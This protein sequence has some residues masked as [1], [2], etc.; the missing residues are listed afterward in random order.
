MTFRNDDDCIPGGYS[1]PGVENKIET[2]RTNLKKFPKVL[3]A[4]SGG[5]DSFFLLKHCV[6]I[7]GKENVAAVFVLTRLITRNDQKRV[8]YFKE[9]LDFDLETLE[10]DLSNEE[11]IMSNP[12]DRCYH[13]KKKIFSLLKEKA[14]EKGIDI[15]VDGS[16]FSDLDEYRPGMQ[17]IEELTVASPLVEA[18]IT[19][20]EIV[21]YLREE[22][23]IEAFY[24]SSS[25]CL[26]TRFPY[27][28]EL[29]EELLNVFGEVET[30][31][32][33]HGIYPVKIRYIADGIRVET[34]PRH[35][36]DILKLR[37]AIVEFCKSKGLKFITIDLEG[38]KSGVWD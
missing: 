37:E 7:L 31:F 8:S 13:C 33:D 1:N 19:T 24:L 16:T 5:K 35:F 20:G 38:I 2:L 12:R 10:I 30:Y 28:M 26:A 3:V 32:V 14:H 22:M 4:F 25:T 11:K 17:A 29:T 9:L 34:P 18:R 36:Q 15:V 21:E 27:D 23:C 6:E